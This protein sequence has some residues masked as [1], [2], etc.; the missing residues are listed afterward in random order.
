[1]VDTGQAKVNGLLVGSLGQVSERLS[2]VHVN[3]MITKQPVDLIMSV[4]I[5]WCNWE[6][7][8]IHLTFIK[9]LADQ[10]CMAKPKV[11][12]VVIRT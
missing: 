3:S 7:K 12:I 9:V 11:T 2:K 6:K 10:S 4:S 1:M 8:F 5:V